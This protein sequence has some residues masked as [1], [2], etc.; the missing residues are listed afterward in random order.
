MPLAPPPAENDGWS[1]TF[2]ELTITTVVRHLADDPDDAQLLFGEH[3]GSEALE[4]RRR[5]SLQVATDLL[6]G[7]AEPHLPDSRF[8]DDPGAR[9]HP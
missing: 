3:A 2:V 7:L 1:T 4:R 5:E 6:A 8:L 9:T